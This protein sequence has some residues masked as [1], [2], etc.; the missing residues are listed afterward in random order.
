LY[1]Q[2]YVP[3]PKTD[4]PKKNR[5]EPG[6]AGRRESKG[7][8]PEASNYHQHAVGATSDRLGRSGEGRVT[9][10]DVSIAYR[11]ATRDKR[12]R[13]TGR[14]SPAGKLANELRLYYRDGWGALDDDRQ[15]RI[16]FSI[17]LHTIANTISNVPAKMT[18][19]W[20]EFAPWLLDEEMVKL[21]AEAIR[22][23]RRWK[24]D[25]L[26]QRIGLT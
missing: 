20:R 26:A 9:H 3:H 10:G 12:N 5:P 2:G 14:F 11:A 15:G 16:L 7:E 21:A 1:P 18:A 13:G 8:N 6:S 4:P 23:H 24:A 25:K 17:L 19:A 22:V